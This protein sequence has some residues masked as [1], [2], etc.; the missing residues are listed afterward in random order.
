M[1]P[2][3]GVVAVILSGRQD[4]AKFVASMVAYD[5]KIELLY[6]MVDEKK[7]GQRRVSE[8]ASLVSSLLDVREM[9]F[10]MLQCFL[11]PALE[12]PMYKQQG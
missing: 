5:P 3:Q 11:D 10:P 12:A 8:V 7:L 1:S 6:H 4:A 9:V 2:E